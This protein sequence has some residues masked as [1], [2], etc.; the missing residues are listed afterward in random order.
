M[1]EV[2]VGRRGERGRR[3]SRAG[4]ACPQVRLQYEGAYV[5]KWGVH[6]HSTT[7]I[8]SFM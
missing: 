6:D 3:L 5:F 1:V 4:L 7:Y 8:Q 2:V